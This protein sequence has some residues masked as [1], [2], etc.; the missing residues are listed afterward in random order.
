[1]SRWD[2]RRV[3]HQFWSIAFTDMPSGDC[4][5]CQPPGTPHKKILLDRNV[6][7]SDFLL[8]STM[9]HEALHATCWALDEEY[10]ERYCIDT[11]RIIIDMG[12]T[13]TGDSIDKIPFID[14]NEACSNTKVIDKEASA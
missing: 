10:V 13:R 2:R 1:M 5:A 12:F 4:G 3:G 7:K 6:K 11:A 8:L 14:Y 9:L